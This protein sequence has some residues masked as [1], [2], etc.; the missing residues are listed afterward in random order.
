MK[1]YSQQGE[2]SIYLGK[3]FHPYQCS[4]VGVDIFG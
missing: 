3:I 1:V 4:T 2:G